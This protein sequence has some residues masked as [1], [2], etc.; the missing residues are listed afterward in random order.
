MAMTLRTDETTN[1]AL[2]RLATRWGVSKQAAAVRAVREA[3]ERMDEDV[4]A[5]AQRYLV[6]D[7]EI[8]T[9]LKDA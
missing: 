5:L 9:R 4:L 6:E 1:Q 7:A 3:A 2:T 8:M